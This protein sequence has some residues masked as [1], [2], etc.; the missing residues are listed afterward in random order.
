MKN[1]LLP[2]LV[3]TTLLL[4]SFLAPAP[5]HA[6]EEADHNALRAIKAAY[7]AAVNAGDPTRLAPHLATNATAVMVTGEAI[8][9]LAGLENY[10][11]KIQTL[12]GPGGSYHFAANVERTDFYGDLALSR[13]TTDDLVRLP[14]G[15][16]LKFNSHWTAVCHREP[17]GWKIL[18]LQATL[19]PVDNVFVRAK[20]AATRVAWAAAGVIAG[21]LLTLLLVRLR[22]RQSRTHPALPPG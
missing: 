9:G 16:E 11:R 1:P 20:L 13:G 3:L 15:K 19:D 7:E 12:L 5:A 10:W 6:D 14:G 18:R 2:R 4:R 17:G 21:L 22:S 8:T